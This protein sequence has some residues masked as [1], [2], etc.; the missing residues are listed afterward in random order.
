MRLSPRYDDTAILSIDGRPDDQAVPVSR[1]RLR[2]EA[3][4]SELGDDDWRAPSRCAG[5]RVQDVVAHLV[6]VNAFWE[7]SVRAGL[8]A[9]PTRV[10][11]AFDP[12]AHPPLLIEPMRA[13]SG[14]E[15]LDQFVASNA[16]FLDALAPL[17]D[18]GWATV[19]ESPAGHVSIRLLAPRTP[20]GMGGSTST[21]LRG[22][23]GVC[24][25]RNPTRS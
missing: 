15:I 6:G 22:R 5:W 20:S 4:L 14:P 19:A 8:A 16:G 7:A 24:R 1:Q 10:L 2:M 9:A 11:A 3:M 23:S 18:D 13:L 21:T 12:A 17:D 25:P